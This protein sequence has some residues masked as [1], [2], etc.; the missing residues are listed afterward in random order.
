MK[1]CNNTTSHHEIVLIFA[2]SLAFLG[3]I[4]STAHSYLLYKETGSIIPFVILGFF[5]ILAF[6]SIK[7]IMRLLNTLEQIKSSSSKQG[8]K[9]E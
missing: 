9:N 2:F 7:N 5:A 6:M 8:M 3:T 1:R 4:F